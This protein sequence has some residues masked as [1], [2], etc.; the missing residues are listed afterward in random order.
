VAPLGFPEADDAQI[1]SPRIA[2]FARLSAIPLPVVHA[3][4]AALQRLARRELD[5][6]HVGRAAAET[7]HRKPEQQHHFAES[8]YEIE[9]AV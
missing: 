1:D 6:P 9:C 3:D 7:S 8:V 2:A 4:A 5:E